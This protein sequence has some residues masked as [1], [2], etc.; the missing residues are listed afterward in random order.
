MGG[1][2]ASEV[3]CDHMRRYTTLIVL[4]SVAVAADGDGE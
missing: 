1:I 2:A 4:S 3:I